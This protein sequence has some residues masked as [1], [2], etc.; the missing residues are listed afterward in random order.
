M[1][2]KQRSCIAR[3]MAIGILSITLGLSGLGVEGWAKIGF[4][5]FQGSAHIL[6][7]TDTNDEPTITIL[8]PASVSSSNARL[9]TQPPLGL[10][11]K[12]RLVALLLFLSVAAEEKA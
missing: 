6:S 2:Q 3:T 9:R 8:R 5:N 11:K 12:K 4:Y 10:S 1:S 7:Q